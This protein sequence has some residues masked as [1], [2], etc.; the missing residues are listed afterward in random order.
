MKVI[1]G[2]GFALFYT[3]IFLVYW[4][5]IST[6]LIVYLIPM[7]HLTHLNG[8]GMIELAGAVLSLLFCFLVRYLRKKSPILFKLLFILH[9][10]MVLHTVHIFANMDKPIKVPAEVYEESN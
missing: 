9:I 7:F 10:I 3:L 8:I 6:W 2:F 5:Q 4:Q 1:K